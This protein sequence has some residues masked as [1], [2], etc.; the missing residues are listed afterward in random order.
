M[1]PKE[2]NISNEVIYKNTWVEQVSEGGLSQPTPLFVSYCAELDHIFNAFNETSLI[3]KKDYIKDLI[4]LADNVECG[5]EVK[6]LFFRSRM[7]FRIRSLKKL[8]ETNSYNKRKNI[9]IIT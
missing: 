1:K 4:T 9:K 7:Y 6:K 5:D 2:P 8:F 3:C